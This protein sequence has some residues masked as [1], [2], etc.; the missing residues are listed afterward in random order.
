M[1]YTV[2]KIISFLL[3]INAN[4]LTATTHTDA[5]K[6]II[7]NRL[8]NYDG[9]KT[10]LL[11]YPC[12]ANTWT[13]YCLEYLTQRPTFAPY[14]VD[15]KNE[16]LAWLAGFDIDIN[17]PP[18]EKTHSLV[19]ATFNKNSDKLIFI[20][21]NPKEAIQRASFVLECKEDLTKAERGK[22]YFENIA[23]FDS[24]NPQNRFLV[25][26]EDLIMEPE[27]TLGEILH[28]L[29]ETPSK[30]KSFMAEYEKHQKKS[31]EIYY[32]SF[33]KAK[34]LLYHSKKMKPGLR[35]RIDSWIEEL[36]PMQWNTY[37]KHRYSEAILKYD[38]TSIVKPIA[39]ATAVVSKALSI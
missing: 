23:T 29:N 22:K 30:L 17:K 16:P 11:S 5:E 9:P 38:S 20:L 12:S 21:R 31:I 27:K 6:E 15:K 14:H 2:N 3:V 34:D 33:S 36:F 8:S 39:L 4:L 1:S 18:I 7:M 13:R 32:E 25:Y 24:W 37:L 19:C 26:Y 35:K 10:W 28:F